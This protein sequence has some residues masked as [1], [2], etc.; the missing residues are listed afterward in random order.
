MI[1]WSRDHWSFLSFCCWW[2]CMYVNR[3]NKQNLFPNFRFFLIWV[4]KKTRRL[5]SSSR[6]KHWIEID[7]C[8]RLFIS[9]TCSSLSIIMMMMISISSLLP[10]LLLSL[11]FL[12]L[13]RFS[14]LLKVSKWKKNHKIILRHF[15]LFWLWWMRFYNNKHPLPKIIINQKNFPIQSKEIT[16]CIR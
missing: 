2:G 4:L 10:S 12:F 8:F 5:S 13:V 1:G 6:R 16:R 15:F 9:V 7:F 11:F 3:T 14:R